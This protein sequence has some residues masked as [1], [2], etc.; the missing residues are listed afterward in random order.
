MTEELKCPH[1]G[2]D[3]YH[4]IGRDTQTGKQRYKCKQCGRGFYRPEDYKP[5]PVGIKCPRCGSTKTVKYGWT[6]L[7]GDWKSE[8]IE[9]LPNGTQELRSV[10]PKPLAIRKQRFKCMNCGRNFYVPKEEKADG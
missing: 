6:I 9:T 8:L 4:R 2:S 5:Q 7:S 10:P 3:D 1:C